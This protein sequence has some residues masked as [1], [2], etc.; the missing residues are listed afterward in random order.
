MASSQQRK[1]RKPNT[2]SVKKQ[3]GPGGAVYDDGIDYTSE[4]KKSDKNDKSETPS[5]IPETQATITE[6]FKKGTEDRDRTEG[7]AENVRSID[8]VLRS[9]D[10]KLKKMVTVD[11]LQR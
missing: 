6:L 2:D 7:G 10:A 1:A 11:H 8:T 5:K 9:L 3:K 4:N